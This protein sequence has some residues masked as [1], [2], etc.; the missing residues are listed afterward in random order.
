MELKALFESYRSHRSQ[1]VKKTQEIVQLHN[2]LS[3]LSADRLASSGVGQVDASRAGLQVDEEIN[4]ART[5][6]KELLQSAFAVAKNVKSSVVNCPAGQSMPLDNDFITRFVRDFEQQVNLEY[7]IVDAICTNT[8]GIDQDSL[9]T[10]LACF[11]YPPYLADSSF[12]AV[13]AAL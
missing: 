5:E 8:P 1:L 6:A 4:E 9:T 10:M 2:K 11:E 7:S 3:Y 12:D 13:V